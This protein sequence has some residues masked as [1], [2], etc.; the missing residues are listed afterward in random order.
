MSNSV[1]RSKPYAEWAR[2]ILFQDQLTKQDISNNY[3][4]PWN[5][6]NE[7]VRKQL[8]LLFHIVDEILR[9]EDDN[10]CEEFKAIQTQ[11]K[12]S[13]TYQLWENLHIT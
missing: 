11:Y 1:L 8:C 4:Y 7:D 13:K 2:K 6:Q 5:T 9:P 12:T 10:C 3:E